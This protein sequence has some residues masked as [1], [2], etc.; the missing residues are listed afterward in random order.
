MVERYHHQWAHN[1]VRDAPYR[2]QHEPMMTE[3]IT[4]YTGRAHRPCRSGK[5]T[6]QGA[7]NISR[8]VDMQSIENSNSTR[9]VRAKITTYYVRS[10]L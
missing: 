3:L 10:T 4:K 2:P 8:R 7:Q 9:N 6:P 1:V 5:H